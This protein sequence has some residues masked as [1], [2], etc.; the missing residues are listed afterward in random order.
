[1]NNLHI[2]RPLHTPL[3]FPFFHHA[4]QHS[5][6]PI[7]FHDF[8]EH[9][10]QLKYPYATKAG[11]YTEFSCIFPKIIAIGHEHSVRTALAQNAFEGGG[12]LAATW[13]RSTIGATR[14]G[15]AALQVV[16][17]LARA[18]LAGELELAGD[19]A[20]SLVGGDGRVEER[21]DVGGN[22]V[23]DLAEGARAL[24]K[25]VQGLG[26]RARTAVA[27]GLQGLLGGGNELGE[28]RGSAV[29]VEDGFVADDAHLDEAPVTGLTPFD[30]LLDL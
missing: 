5:S 1:M 10:P 26:G 4:L 9:Y 3:R 18:A 27:S 11:L 12:L 2:Y 16:S 14:S 7:S 6:I 13:N 21:L 30:D 15:P 8:K 19:K 17:G 23:D 28:F 29:P 22:D 24:L 25:D 20:T